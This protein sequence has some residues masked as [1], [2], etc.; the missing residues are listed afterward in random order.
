MINNIKMQYTLVDSSPDSF[1]DD[2]PMYHY[3]ITLYYADRSYQSWYSVGIGHSELFNDIKIWEKLRTPEY[4][5]LA[6]IRNTILNKKNLVFFPWHLNYHKSFFKPVFELGKKYLKP[7]ELKTVLCSIIS[8][9]ST[10]ENSFT[11]EDFC[12]ELGYDTDSRKAY[13][14]WE[15]CKEQ[16]EKFKYFAGRELYDYLIEKYTNGELE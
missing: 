16:N 13:R 6:A 12:S 7:L 14:T 3:C 11:F 10:A 9:C 2:T 4:N 1:M 5:D 15:A 8:D